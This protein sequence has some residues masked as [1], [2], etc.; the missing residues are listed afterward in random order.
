MLN[1]LPSGFGIIQNTHFLTQ[2][3]TEIDLC[4]SPITSVNVSFVYDE[5]V[6]EFINSAGE[7]V[8]TDYTVIPSTSDAT[9]LSVAT[10]ISD[11]L[12]SQISLL[13]T[14][15]HSGVIRTA[16]GDFPYNIEEDISSFSLIGK[17]EYL[18]S[19]SIISDEQRIGLY[20][21]LSMSNSDDYG[22]GSKTFIDNTI[23]A[24]SV[25]NE[26]QDT[27]LTEKLDKTTNAI[28]ALPSYNA[29]VSRTI[30]TF[31]VRVFYDTS[32][33]MT[34]SVAAKIANEFVNIY[35]YFVVNK[36]FLAPVPY[37]TSYYSVYLLPADEMSGASTTIDPTTGRSHIKIG[38][39]TASSTT[40]NVTLAHEFNHAVMTAYHIP[41]TG[42]TDAS[43]LWW[44]HDGFSSMAAM[45][46]TSNNSDRYKNHIN[47]YL[48]HSNL[49]IFN[50]TVD[51]FHYGALMFPLYIYTY[52]GGWTTIEDIYY[53]YENAGNP[54]DAITN[55]PYV[56]T[57]RNAFSA[58]V[59]RNYKPTAYY[60]YATASWGT[61]IVLSNAFP[62]AMSG[63][64][65]VHP[66]ACHYQKFQ[67]T[68]NIGTAYFTLEINAT[69]TSGFY[70]NVITETATGALSITAVYSNF[71]RVTIP[72]V[73]FGATIKKVILVP[74]NTNTSGGSM[75]YTLSASTTN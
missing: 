61:G 40:Y 34:T 69:N 48:T 15:T 2:E 42:G 10:S 66:M 26:S 1:S 51:L 70:L 46:Y 17:I 55:S 65:M 71:T 24:Y 27:L 62:P 36:G 50:T 12:I 37:A 60:T 14:I 22:I 6:P 11:N 8:L 4:I 9:S 49:S 29:Y 19:N 45:I 18:Y 73:N 63:R 58:M 7:V 59:T 67:S 72:Q 41:C 23:R 44:F 47:A 32:K 74:V 68:I 56:S 3:K 53:Q 64:F 75:I 52:L 30:G 57:Y 5:L 38:Y 13:R 20:C 43:N 16:G 25:N 28:N 31:Q 54:F 35:N 21:D 39:G 33:G